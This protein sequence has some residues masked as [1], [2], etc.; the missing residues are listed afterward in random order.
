MVALLSH[1]AQG[2]LTA[3]A[4]FHGTA[5]QRSRSRSRSPTGVASAPLPPLASLPADVAARLD[6]AAAEAWQSRWVAPLPILQAGV[7]PATV[8]VLRALSGSGKSTL[9]RALTAG[10]ND[11]GTPPAA[12]VCSADDYFVE[13]GGGVYAFDPALLPDAHAACRERV[14]ESLLSGVPLVVVD[15]THTRE[16][17]YA[18]L[19]DLVQVRPRQEGRG[20]G[21]GG[22][23]LGCRR[24]DDVAASRQHGC[25]VT[26]Q[27]THPPSTWAW[28]QAP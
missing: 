8:V 19:L 15:N 7:F 27:R 26:K 3:M 12:V 5:R 24:R 17:E 14:R 23:V 6:A 18:P 20:G 22:G 28:C 10:L 25:W 11:C 2:G 13:R 4:S 1:S 16:F 21:G 9:A